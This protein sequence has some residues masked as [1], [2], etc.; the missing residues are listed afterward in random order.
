MYHQ[1]QESDE[2]LRL[3]IIQSE[4][5]TC[6]WLVAELAELTITAEVAAG[7]AD[8]VR[9]LEKEEFD[10]CL[11]A[12]STEPPW[13]WLSPALHVH[14]SHAPLISLPLGDR[15]LDSIAS[16]AERRDYVRSLK[17]LLQAAAQLSARSRAVRRSR[18]YHS[19][20]QLIEAL[21]ARDRFERGESERVAR[22]AVAIAE[23]VGGLNRTQVRLAAEL[24][25]VG[26]LAVPG[27]IAEKATRLSE[28]EREEVRRHPIYGLQFLRPL[29][30]DPAVLAGVAWHHERWDGSGY[31]DGLKGRQIPVIAR[32]IAVAEALHAITSP[33]PYRNARSWA[34]AFHELEAGSGTQF[35]PEVVE[36]T[37]R[38]AAQLVQHDAEAGEECIGRLTPQTST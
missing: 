31:P 33:R 25:D 15:G 22:L 23:H 7:E 17:V 36:T 20:R 3:L 28:A 10:V 35:D 27:G 29:I 34:E 4:P 13:S 18:E 9:A 26:S 19:A 1:P 2:G 11:D 5:S 32:V 38:I 6:A 12:S 24:H 37:L 21:E 14:A 30:N 8:T 16:D